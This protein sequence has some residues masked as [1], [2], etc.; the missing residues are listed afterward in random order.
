MWQTILD[1]ML[2][3]VPDT[4]DKR[5]GSFIYDALAPPAKQ[6]E[7]FDTKI[8]QVQD[9]L[10]IEN[11]ESPELDQRVNER[12]GIIRKPATRATGQVVI[13]GNGSI[14][15]N[16]LFETTGGIQFRAIETKQVVGSA[17]VAIESMIEGAIGNVAANTIT[18]FPIT[19]SGITSVTNL[20]S[21]ANGYN[22]ESDGDLLHR[23][24]EHIRTPATSGNVAH[25]KNWAKEV[26]GVGD[27]KVVPLW[28]GNNTVKV[29]VIDANRLP[30]TTQLVSEVQQYI[31][32]NK[33]GLGMGQ[34]PIGAYTTVVSA[35]GVAININVSVVLS[36]DSN[37]QNAKQNITNKLIEHL[38]SI[39][40]VDNIV[41]FARIGSV[42]LSSD[43]VEDYQNLRINNGTSNITIG[44]E[45]VAVVGTVVLNVLP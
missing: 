40:F 28:N 22:Q 14:N 38:Q 6:F 18:L 31:D 43:G 2:N 10:T 7:T 25:Y 34:A 42:I 17:T 26:A 3:V 12:T 21:I 29:I 33:G 35:Q 15:V 37:E 24:F 23:Y 5:K 9:K 4:L 44:N 30:A 11:L 32:P 45:Q 19:L 36:N 16:D 8:N 39:A 27:A 41:S 13:T 20:A 1:L